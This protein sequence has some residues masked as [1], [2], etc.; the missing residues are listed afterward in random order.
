M[1][2]IDREHWYFEGDERGVRL[3]SPAESLLRSADF[4]EKRV[5][6]QRFRGAYAVAGLLRVLARKQ[7]ELERVIEADPSSEHVVIAQGNELFFDEFGKTVFEDVH[8]ALYH[9]ALSSKHKPIPLSL[10]Y[11]IRNKG[12]PHDEIYCITPEMQYRKREIFTL[13]SMPQY[14][15]EGSL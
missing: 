4:W 15:I 5:G 8:S 12:I 1:G 6:N 14:I 7:G 2:A 3:E 9:L 13:Y 11:R 10:I